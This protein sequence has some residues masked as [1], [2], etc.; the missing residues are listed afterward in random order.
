MI[1]KVTHTTTYD[2]TNS[3]S[4]S[5]HL[6][7]LTPRELPHQ[8]C[9]RNEVLIDPQPAVSEQHL[10]YFGNAVKFVTIEGA[11]E[12]LTV[13]SASD[14]SVVSPRVSAPAETPAWESVREFTRG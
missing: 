4:L 8:R 14:V 3:V 7:R 5:H 9:L 10:D 12:T 1:Y 13:K 6:M 2:Y 11:H